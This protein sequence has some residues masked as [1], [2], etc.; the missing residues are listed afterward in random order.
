M[1]C[2]ASRAGSSTAGWRLLASSTRAP[3]CCC[4]A[5]PGSAASRPGTPLDRDRVAESVAA[6]EDSVL[7]V[8]GP[9]GSGKTYAG[10]RVIVYLLRAGARVG[11]AA[12]SH[13]AIHNLL[14]EVE[15]VA[16][17]G[18]VPFVG[19]KKGSKDHP[20]TLYDGRYV[21]TSTDNDDFPPPREE[22]QLIAGTSWLFARD[23]MRDAVDVLVIDEAGQV[24]L[25]DALAIA[26]AAHS[27]VLL[28]D[29]QQ[30]AH[31]S[32]GTHPRGSGVSVLEHLLGPRDT[33]PPEDGILLNRTWRMHPDV[34]TFGRVGERRLDRA[35]VADWSGFLPP[36]HR[37]VHAIFPHTALRRSSP[38]AFSVPVATAGWV[39]ARRWFR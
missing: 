29:P 18:G 31:V 12:T 6:L 28:G 9:P 16:H 26:Q 8:Q 30:L 27:V 33:V 11:V 25:A 17:D 24:A 35:A 4:V 20:E 23:A 38:S 3:T 13:K 22:V 37:T 34:C 21:L 39:V 19:L 32:Q 15:D 5:G 36:P 7:F 2:A 10:A 1:P 14:A